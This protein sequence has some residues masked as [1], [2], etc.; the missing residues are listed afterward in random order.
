M[1]R[2]FLIIATCT[3]TCTATAQVL[4]CIHTKDGSVYNGFI[5]EQIIG[6]QVSI[7]AENASI[8]FN[9]KDIS[10]QRFDYFDFDRLSD[11]SKELVR[12][13]CEDSMLNLTSFEYNGVYYENLYVCETADST[14]R[15]F[16]LTPRTYWIPWSSLNKIV[17]KSH[18]EVPYGI[19]DIITLKSGERL[20]GQIIEQDIAKSIS[21]RDK[22]GRIHVINSTDI[23]STMQDVI[24]TKHTI[25]DQTPILDRIILS[26]GEHLMGVITS[27]VMG[28]YVSIQTKHQD[29]PHRV[30]YSDITK[31]QKTRNQEY[32]PYVP[33]TTKVVRLND[34]D[35][36]TISLEAREGMYHNLE[37]FEYSYF[38][39]DEL[40]LSLK[41]I[42][43]GKTVTLYEYKG[44]PSAAYGRSKKGQVIGQFIGP[45]DQPIYETTFYVEDDFMVCDITV[46]KPGKYFLSI[47]GFET[48]LNIMFDSTHK[49]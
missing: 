36:E 31:Y 7:Y 16:A 15:M 39:G 13:Q 41:N 46:K 40:K 37:E 44:I 2:L 43:H 22:T 19:I 12:Y 47:D 27:R 25:W 33:D 34:I 8:V 42:P 32:K 11:S 48:G 26:N 1:R 24:S 23:L 20:V 49:N 21:L 3:F 45:N 18:E 29:Q 4:D 6:K 10:N 17:R 38:V 35:V 30:A 28:Q 14:I 9:K 5:S